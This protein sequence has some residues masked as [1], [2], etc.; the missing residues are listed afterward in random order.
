MGEIV[1]QVL[2]LKSLGFQGM[3]VNVNVIPEWSSH[4]FVCF[5]FFFAF[6]G[7]FLRKKWQSSCQAWPVAHFWKRRPR[8]TC[9][10]KTCFVSCFYWVIYLWKWVLRCTRKYSPDTWVFVPQPIERKGFRCDVVWATLTAP[11]LPTPDVPAYAPIYSSCR[12]RLQIQVVEADVAPEITPRTSLA[13][14]NKSSVG[15]ERK[16][17]RKRSFLPPPLADL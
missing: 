3:F 11:S 2:L 1:E 8:R 9:T 12:P 17:K 6:L 7:W 10:L 13:C 4:A 15:W 14:F 5:W 16:R